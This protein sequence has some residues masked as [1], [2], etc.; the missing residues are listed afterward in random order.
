MLAVVEGVELLAPLGLRKASGVVVELLALRG[1]EAPASSRGIGRFSSK[2]KAWLT[3]DSD[4]KEAY[5]S[6]KG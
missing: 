3:C 2:G 1:S 5:L 6:V 4:G